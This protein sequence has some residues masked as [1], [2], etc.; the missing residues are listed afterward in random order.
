MLVETGDPCLGGEQGQAGFTHRVISHKQRFGE[1]TEPAW[2]RA[3]APQGD[4]SAGVTSHPTACPG[5]LPPG[6]R[7]THIYF[8]FLKCKRRGK[9]T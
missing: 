3:P 2:L 6:P 9:S 7:L 8:L 1:P 5:V 4:T